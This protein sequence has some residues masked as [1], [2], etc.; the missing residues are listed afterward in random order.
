[1]QSSYVSSDTG[2]ESM[3]GIR[4][5]HFITYTSAAGID[6]CLNA[7]T[8]QGFVPEEKTIW[9]RERIGRTGERLELALD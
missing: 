9:L 4:F 8:A 7:Y 2:G 1:M 5:D 3:T 6:Y